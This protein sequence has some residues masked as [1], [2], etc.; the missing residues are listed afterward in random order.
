MDPLA[1]LTAQVQATTGAEQSAIVLIQ[2]LAAALT[3]AG[4]NPAKLQAI[5][6]SLNASSTALAAAVV[7]N[8]PPV[9][10]TPPAQAKKP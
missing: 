10:P 9:P 5:V 7:A 8:S 2:G 1:G 3:A 6:D 4:T